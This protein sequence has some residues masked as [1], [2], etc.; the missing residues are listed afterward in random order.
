MASK[1]CWRSRVILSEH[2]AKSADKRSLRLMSTKI[3]P[4]HIE[5]L[6]YLRLTEMH[7]LLGVLQ[8]F[9]PNDV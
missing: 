8:P 5:S 6:E 9:F 7:E 1:L 2:S 3:A 4:I